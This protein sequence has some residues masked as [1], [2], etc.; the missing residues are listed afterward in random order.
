MSFCSVFCLPL[1]C[2]ILLAQDFLQKKQ[3]IKLSNSELGKGLLSTEFDLSI[4]PL[5]GGMVSE[6]SLQSKQ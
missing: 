2:I 1:S 6:R 5:G 4:S 3:G